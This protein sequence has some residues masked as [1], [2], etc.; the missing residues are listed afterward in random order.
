[1]SAA[2]AVVLVLAGLSETVGRILP[3]VARRH[4]ATRATVI[5]LLVAGTVIQALLFGSWPLLAWTVAGL[6]DPGPAG[7]A[8][9]WTA[10]GLVPLL[11]CAVYAFPLLGPALHLLVLGLAGIALSEQLAAAGPGWWPAVGCVAGAGG[12]L[13]LVL[14]GIR[15]AVG[16]W[17][18]APLPVGRTP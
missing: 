10:G 15:R 8:P 4:R 14:A 17:G 9:A 7:P 12:L 1:M 6:L 3:L 11:F 16:S 13:A 18:A 5:R 2:T